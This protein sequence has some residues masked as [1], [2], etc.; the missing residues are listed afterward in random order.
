MPLREN[1]TKIKV[2]QPDSY[3]KF[4]PGD[5]AIAMAGQSPQIKWAYWTTIVH[6]RCHNHCKGLENDEKFLRRLSELE[7]D[8]DWKIFYS[9]IF[10]S[11]FMLDE[12]GLWQQMR[13]QLDYIDNKLTMEKWS[14]RGKAGANVRWRKKK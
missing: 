4:V 11:Y 1:F 6:Y 7:N 14:R 3:I 10:G 8:K 2:M 13:T 5:F 12:N 9:L